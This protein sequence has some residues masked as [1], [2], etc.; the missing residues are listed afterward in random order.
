MEPLFLSL[1]SL[2]L[3]GLTTGAKDK[4]VLLCLHGWLDNAASFAPLAPYLE[5]YQLI[6]PDW[7][8]HGLSEHKAEYYH[9]ADWIDDLYQ[10][11]ESIGLDRIHLLGHS[12]G[13]LIACCFTAAFPE[14]V[15]SLTLVE[16]AG[17]LSQSID[18]TTSHL[19]DAVLN[20]TRLK[21]KLLRGRMQKAD[22]VKA[23]MI[24]SE[25]DE[26]S[27]ALLVERGSE[28]RQGL[29][30]WRADEKLKT[31]SPLRMSETQAC[32]LISSIQCPCLVILGIEGFK[33][34]KSQIKLRKKHFSRLIIKEL[35]GK[36]HLHMTHPGDVAVELNNFLRYSQL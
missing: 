32:E 25:L 13:A 20:R 22:L 35:P 7:P 33:G 10:I 12:M 5:D 6:C 26:Q 23:R 24:T 15:A 18:T 29:W 21:K 30:Y 2:K 36:H 31:L 9:F 3:S 17:P 16:G 27:A 19:R 28:C 11:I 1:D 8:G 4:P 34:M 14:K